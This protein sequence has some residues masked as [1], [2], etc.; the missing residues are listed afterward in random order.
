MRQVPASSFLLPCHKLAPVLACRPMTISR[1]RK[2]AIR[3]G[4]LKV[5]KTHSY[6]SD[7]KGEATEFQFLDGSMSKNLKTNR[8][9]GRQHLRIQCK[10]RINSLTSLNSLTLHISQI[11]QD[12]PGQ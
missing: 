7:G 6:R 2:K 4:Y 5:V 11:S 9:P 8:E 1:Y 3:D 12:H 10:A